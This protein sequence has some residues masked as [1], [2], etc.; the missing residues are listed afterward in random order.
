[1]KIFGFTLLRNGIKYDYSFKECLSSLNAVTEKTY[2]A[3]GASEDGT[4]DV[5]NSL[6]NIKVIP[7]VWDDALRDGGLILSQQTNVALNTLREDYG[8]SDDAW[9]IYLQCDEVF[10][11]DD[12]QLIKNDI[13]KAQAEGCDAISFRYFHFWMDHHHIAINKKWYP[14][15]IRAVK[16]K[17]NI[18]SWGDAQSFRHQTKVYESDA[19]I[20]HYGHVREKESYLQKKADILKLYHSDERIFKY[21][22][23]EKKF[24][25]QTETLLYWGSHPEIMKERVLRMGDI[26]QLDPVDNL[27]IIGS[28]N[29][30]PLKFVE[31]IV[32]KKIHFVRSRGEV[33]KNRRDSIWSLESSWKDRLLPS[34]RIPTQMRSKL[35][36]RW[37]QET[38]L[39]LQLSKM[40]VA[41]NL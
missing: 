2:L 23:R 34:Q 38:I 22:R 30:L 32:A 24:D 27:Y 14:Q 33:P 20:Y 19:R 8:E 16:V 11:Q 6:P 26:W 4:E 28:Q 18:E 15:E 31:Q 39:M 3:L 7:T 41:V 36:R 29:D 17:T 10:H 13:A 21:K 1:M 9:G 37:P 12:Y 35:A 25:R 5:I 40:M